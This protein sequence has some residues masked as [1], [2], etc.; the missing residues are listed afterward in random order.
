[1]ED[2]KEE[3]ESSPKKTKAEKEEDKVLK[4]LETIRQLRG[5]ELE[6]VEA[7]VQRQTWGEGGNVTL[8]KLHQILDDNDLGMIYGPGKYLVNY[9]YVNSA[10]ENCRKAIRYN[11]GAEF[12]DLHR[13]Y[14]HETGRQCY[15][16][17]DTAISGQKPGLGFQLS[18]LLNQEKL[19]SLM[20]LGTAIK[21]MLGSGSNDKLFEMQNQL[22]KTMMTSQQ[23]QQPKIID[24]LLGVAVNRLLEGNKPQPQ[25]N[26]LSS[27]KEQLSLF[28]DMRD[29][30]S[31]EPVSAEGGTMSKI[32]EM[33]LPMLPGLL[34]KFG[35]NIEAA[36]KA[37]LK[38]PLV[39]GYL[40]DTT[41]QKELYQAI[42]RKDGVQAANAWASGF[43]IDPAQFAHTGQ[44]NR[45]GTNSGEV[46]L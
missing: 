38:N 30:I 29:L 1:M 17:N 9:L 2:E 16:M 39:K 28:Q 37:Q 21:S 4:K 46:V 36:A 5:E 32:V 8:P 45:L 19:Q 33:V 31:P 6:E 12:A 13:K 41:T 26:P 35:G 18:D 20:M 34:E 14:C 15:L 11:I 25:Q 24:N 10:G 44:A 22:I 7:Y 42:A 43:G 27:M 23:V 40:K 3:L